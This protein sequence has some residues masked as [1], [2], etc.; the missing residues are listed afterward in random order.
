MSDVTQKYRV[1]APNIISQR[2]RFLSVGETVEL[3]PH[4]AATEWPGALATLEGEPV[5]KRTLAD[6]VASLHVVLA[7]ARPHERVQMIQTQLAGLTPD[8]A[9]ETRGHLEGLLAQA[10]QEA[11]QAQAAK[12]DA[13]AEVPKTSK[14]ARVPPTSPAPVTESTGS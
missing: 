12:T 1:I 14:A 9:P 5:R 8:A 11:S 13:A 6:D 7:S 10:M 2:G 3:E 4:I